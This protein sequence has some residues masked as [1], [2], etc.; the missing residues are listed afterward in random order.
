M[1]EQDEENLHI[2]KT[3]LQK[4][5]AHHTA[6]AS[7]DPKLTKRKHLSKEKWTGDLK[8]SNFADKLDAE[9]KNFD[10]AQAAGPV[11]KQLVCLRSET[12]VL[13]EDQEE[14][15]PLPFDA[16]LVI[17]SLTDE[18]FRKKNFQGVL[19]YYFESL[20]L[21]K[22]FSEDV[23]L[24]LV[25]AVSLAAKLEA[26]CGLVTCSRVG[27]EE[28]LRNISSDLKFTRLSR[29]DIYESVRNKLKTSEY[30]LVSYH[31]TPLDE[32]NGHLGDY[33]RLNAEVETFGS[34]RDLQL[35][36][37]LLLKNNEGLK[38]LVE[39]ASIKE[40][41]F[42]QTLL[43]D[44]ERHGL[45]QL[46]SFSPRC[47]F[48]RVN[49]V[50]VLDDMTELGFVG[51]DPSAMLSY[52]ELSVLVLQLARFHSCSLI[53]EEMLTEKEGKP[54]RLTDLY[55]DYMKDVGKYFFYEK[56]AYAA[57]TDGI[58]YCIELFPEVATQMPLEE[59]KARAVKLYEVNLTKC[60]DYRE[61]RRAVC[62]G[63]MY[64][65]NTLIKYGDAGKPVEGRLIDFQLFKYALPAEDLLVFIYI[66]STKDTRDEYMDILI[67]EYYAE[68]SRCLRVFGFDAD[69]VYNKTD[70]Q[71]SVRYLQ[72]LAICH[73]M[74]YNHYVKA[75][76]EVRQDIFT[77]E[78]KHK[79][80]L[81][82]HMRE[83]IDLAMVSDDYKKLHEGMIR[84]FYDICS[85]EDFED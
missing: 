71:T 21:K 70:F 69:V 77:N 25:K 30:E 84:D 31:I 14:Y 42:Y 66:N 64:A 46:M 2:I 23:F 80:Y 81:I 29:E 6:G 36:I 63:D 33:F 76:G 37:K 32:K 12:V 39:T 59:F 11:V 50:L 24:G 78:E 62:H 75:P 17:F 51:F 85:R 56:T 26:A 48:S 38:L 15:V 28:L 52:D 57:S 54:V 49:N 13:N 19:H 7:F 43:A 9:I 67:E 1:S 45:D 44:F 55:G 58:T 60:K 4:L 79:Y 27:F 47:Y 73:A 34:K 22:S 20:R 8:L 5:A 35:F 83:F 40:E 3:I 16:L 61:F 74:M 68:M 10:D 72:S 18:Q 41:F 65:A 53:V 82:E